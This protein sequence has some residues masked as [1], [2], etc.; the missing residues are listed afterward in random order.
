MMA[1][2]IL[3]TALPLEA[4]Q[5]FSQAFLPYLRSVISGYTGQKHESDRAAETR[6]ALERATVA[7]RGQLS[8]SFEWLR[9]PLAVW[10]DSL[11]AAASS[12]S[13]QTD[14]ASTGDVGRKESAGVVPKKTVLM[15]GS[16]MVAPPA[17]AE[18]CSRPDVQLIVGESGA[19]VCCSAYGRL[20]SNGL[21]S[22]S[23]IL[24]DAERLTAPYPNA[25]PVLVDMGDLAAV[26][27]LVAEADVVIRYAVY[28]LPHSSADVPFSL[29]PVPFHPS[30]AELCIRN[31]KHLVT[32]SYIS[33]AM[34]ELH[35][36]CV[37][38]L[39]P[40]RPT[41]EI[42]SLHSAVA[43]DVLLM[44]EIGLDPGIDH[45]SALSLIESLR[46]QNK[47]IVSF[48]S[49]CGGLPAPEDAEVPLGYKFS[50]SPKGVL[51][52]ASNAARFK[53]YGEVRIR[54][55]NH[56]RVACLTGDSSVRNARSTETTC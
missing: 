48:T 26:E 27:R 17:V 35:D 6:E 14:A 40:C 9:R 38:L 47:E 44:N 28:L 49:F 45:C 15:L 23:N 54:P 7:N 43:A 13:S 19:F 50:W 5:H 41:I 11:R 36:R 33:P 20:T 39:R 18:I 4:S 8:S 34:K 56:K 25:T 22:A 10:Q 16:G 46:A 12:A 32:A 21:I 52:A 1:V 29:L 2:D 51:T 53:L 3:P 24:P 37:L 55:L 42:C 31:R 30:V